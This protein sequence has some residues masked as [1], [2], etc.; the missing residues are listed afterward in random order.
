M[1]KSTY[2][3]VFLISCL[4]LLNACKSDVD[5]S[6]IDMSSQINLGVALPIGTMSA[7][8]GDFL[9]DSLI[10]QIMVDEMGVFHFCDTLPLQTRDF[11]SIDLTKY[12]LHTKEPEKFYIREQYPASQ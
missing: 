1:K 4:G 11:H 2:F 6:N 5:L 3:I 12:L 8:I 7:T 9:G 10:E